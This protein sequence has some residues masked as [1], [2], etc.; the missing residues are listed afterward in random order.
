M[1]LFPREFRLMGWIYLIELVVPLL[2]SFTAP[3]VAQRVTG[4]AGTVVFAV[5][6]VLSF[7]VK[8]P[9]IVAC[10]EVAITALLEVA[11]NPGFAWLVI[12][13]AALLTSRYGGRRLA[14]V[15]V[16]IDAVAA[17][18]AW[19]W[20]AVTH[21][22][23]GAFLAQELPSLL[24][25]LVVSSA[26]AAGSL[27][28]RRVMAAKV[29]LEQANQQ[30]ERLTK[31]AERER[32]SRDLHDVIG[33]DLS[34]IAL[35]AQL[36]ERLIEREPGRAREEAREAGQTARESLARVRQYIADMSQPDLSHEWQAAQRILQAAGIACKMVDEMDNSEEQWPCAALAMC[37]RE[38]VTNA[39][40]HSGAKRA[41]IHLIAAAGGLRLI[42]ADDG[43]GMAP[44]AGSAGGRGVAGMLARMTSVG[45][46]AA[47][48]SRGEWLRGGRPEDVALPFR[49]GTAW[50][51]T[52]PTNA[53]AANDDAPASAERTAAA[54]P[55][56]SAK[57]MAL[58][59]QDA[60]A[61]PFEAGA[62]RQAG[63]TG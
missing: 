5:L 11:I 28:Q 8:R 55:V 29:A 22:T 15:L 32:I 52:A 40:R 53:G 1:R 42:V 23:L 3:A 39:V 44:G 2:F 37:L 41:D 19:L 58:C 56:A 59:P 34:L 36:I 21:T 14:R 4:A 48:W 57:S 24:S 63:V 61:A 13:P 62:R 30:I 12:Y 6:Y 16:A 27:W 60:A 43:R 46:H 10:S 50:V 49:R 45:G 51:F 35:K 20:L 9:W 18:A 54:V 47:V 17:S 7:R 38:S 33:H 31:S 25:A 26:V